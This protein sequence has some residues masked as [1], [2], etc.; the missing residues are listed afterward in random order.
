MVEGFL[1]LVELVSDGVQLRLLEVAFFLGA[2]GSA[3]LRRLAQLLQISDRIF[4]VPNRHVFLV[5]LDNSCFQ[6]LVIID[7]SQNIKNVVSQLFLY[8]V[9]NFDVTDHLL[10]LGLEPP[11]LELEVGDYQF[12]VSLD[13]SEMLHFL[14]HLGGLLPQTRDALRAG[15]DIFFELFYLVI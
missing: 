14:L 12:Q 13:P 6:L 10:I 15:L 5:H 8:L 7:V 9:L 3:R 11:H 4:I 1:A 2:L